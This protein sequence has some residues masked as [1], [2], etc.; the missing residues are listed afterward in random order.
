MVQK[1]IA[2]LGDEE[3]D[4]LIVKRPQRLPYQTYTQAFQF[5]HLHFYISE[6]IQEAELYTDMIYKISTACEQDIVFI[7]LNTPGGNLAA[8]VQIINAMQNSLARI[9][10]VLDGIC[11]SLGTLI[12]L[13]GDEMVV[14][15]HCMMMFH[16]FRGGVVGKGHEQAAEL[17]ATIKWFSSL[18]KKIYV[19]FLA[20][21]EFSAILRGEDLWMHSAEIRKRLDRMLRMIETPE[22]KRP[23]KPKAELIEVIETNSIPVDPVPPVS[24][25]KRK[26]KVDKKATT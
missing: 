26:P 13:A 14:N 24:T 1:Q 20:E 6:D 11:Y 8:G 16:N 18:A 25:R 10:T 23:R 4:E 22:G 5:Q 2:R 9:V 15:D 19:P 21:E 12:F 7:H 3:E 17:E